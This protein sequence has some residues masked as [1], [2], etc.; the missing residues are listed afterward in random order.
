MWL[1]FD[2]PSGLTLSIRP[3]LHLLLAARQVEGE[4]RHHLLREAARGLDAAGAL[5]AIAAV[6]AL[7]SLLS[8]NR[9]PPPTAVPPPATQSAPIPHGTLPERAEVL[10]AGD[11]TAQRGWTA[12]PV[13]RLRVLGDP[14]PNGQRLS[15]SLPVLD[16]AWTAGLSPDPTLHLLVQG[17]PEVHDAQVGVLGGLRS[18]SETVAAIRQARAEGRSVKLA[19]ELTPA[20]PNPTALFEH[21]RSLAPDAVTIKPFKAPQDHP[22]AI[23][24]GHVPDLRRGYEEF[25]AYLCGRDEEETAAILRL[26][27]PN[28]YFKRHV[29]RALAR[30]KLPYRCPAAKW[31]VDA[32]EGGA[33]FPCS[34]FR[35]SNLLPVGDLDHGFDPDLARVFAVEAHVDAKPVCRDCWARYLCGGGCYYLATLHHGSPLVPDPVD[36]ALAQAVIEVCLG[37][38]RRLQERFPEVARG[39][40]VEKEGEQVWA[41]TSHRS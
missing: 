36:C 14:L 40:V 26:L 24:A 10:V 9:L 21:L 2:A 12:G 41:D 17:P 11:G 1:L 19:A 28:D 23:G 35:R 3:P 8:R 18:Y 34:S 39:L 32:D 31:M 15:L 4:E 25:S 7:D 13:P 20:F 29:V 38:A 30:K 27:S 22:L 37:A 33:L 5:D 16:T 6:A